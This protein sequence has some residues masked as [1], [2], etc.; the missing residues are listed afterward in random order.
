MILGTTVKAITPQLQ[1]IEG[2][3]VGEFLSE[4]RRHM[5]SV[6]VTIDGKQQRFNVDKATLNYTSEF[7]ELYEAMKQDVD[8]KAKEGNEKIKTIASKYNEKVE[9]ITNKVIGKPYAEPFI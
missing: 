5:V 6:L 4:D 2:E 7:K 3:V 8:E 1:E 9:Q